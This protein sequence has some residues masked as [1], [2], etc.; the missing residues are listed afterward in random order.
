MSRFL[1]IVTAYLA[2]SGLLIFRLFPEHREQSWIKPAALGAALLALVLQGWMLFT[3][4]ITQTGLNFSFFNALSLACWMISGIL[5]VS[6]ITKPVENLGIALFPCAALAVFLEWRFPGNHILADSQQLG[7]RL[8]ILTS[9]LA[10]SLL[11]LASMQALMLAIQ[12]HSLHSHHPRGLIRSLPPLQTMET[13]LFEMIVIGFILLNLS[14]IS[15]FL[16][17]ENMFAQRMVHKTVLSLLGWCVFGGLLWGRF[18]YGWR[19]R[20]AIIWTL[21]G[22]VTLMLGYFGSKAVIELI[23]ERG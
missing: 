21:S 6:S 9:M 3:A 13:L 1:L 5:L 10:Y 7:L 15:G 4:L 8:H 22:F 18:R 14:L 20:T 2:A 23:L 11:A 16:F 19:G 17:L 12:D